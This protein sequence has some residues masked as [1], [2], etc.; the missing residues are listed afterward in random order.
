MPSLETKCLVVQDIYII[1]TNIN[2]LTLCC[3]LDLGSSN[4]IFITGHVAYVDVS[5]DHVWQPRSQ[6]LRKYSRKS[7]FNHWSPNC[8]LDHEDSNQNT[9]QTTTTKSAQPS[10]SWC[11]I[12]ILRL[13]AKGS[14][15]QKISSGQTFIDILKFCCDLDLLHSNPT[16]A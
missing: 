10:V 14:S 12:T 7:Y 8:D 3:D 9:K 1:W 15:I 16:F 11:C 13:V 6:Q 5:S 2:I 4:P